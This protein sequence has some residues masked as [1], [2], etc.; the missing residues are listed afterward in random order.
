M[1]D[2]TDNTIEINLSCGDACRVSYLLNNEQ[3]VRC[4]IIGDQP[5]FYMDF[6]GA[7][8]DLDDF[9]NF[10]LTEDPFGFESIEESVKRLHNRLKDGFSDTPEHDRKNEKRYGGFLDAAMQ[11][12]E[13]TSDDVNRPN[14]L[15]Q[16]EFMKADLI[17]TLNKSRVT[18]EY[19]AYGK[20]FDMDFIYTSQIETAVYDKESGHIYMNPSLDKTNQLLLALRELRR[21]WQHRNG[22]LLHPLTFHPDQAILVNR[23]QIADLAVAVIRGA[24]ELQLSDEKDAWDKIENSSMGDLARAFARESFMDFRTLNNGV[25]AAAVFEAWFLSDRCREVDRDLIQ[26]MLADYQGYVFENQQSSIQIGAELV[27]TLGKMPF[28]KNYLASHIN[29]IMNDALFT[30]VR[31]RSNGNF[32]WFIKF[33]RSFRETEQ[34]LQTGESNKSRETLSGDNQK[35]KRFGDHEKENI[36]SLPRGKVADNVSADGTTG[37]NIIDFRKR[38]SER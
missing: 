31:D 33:E 36:V 7:E 32:L 18:R 2:T 27:I 24:W 37:A 14:D 8:Y 12:T 5:L 6:E 21:M 17:A 30:E 38:T 34:E 29:T 11:M 19:I 22:V 3:P 20:T 13:K 23:V 25:A 15:N 35:D 28:G 10:E 1:R 16:H 26:Q 4:T 9:E